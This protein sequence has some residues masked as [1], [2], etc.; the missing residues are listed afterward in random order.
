MNNKNLGN[1]IVNKYFILL[2]Y[3]VLIWGRYDT[4]KKNWFSRYLVDS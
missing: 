3:K 2:Y 1:S 4:L